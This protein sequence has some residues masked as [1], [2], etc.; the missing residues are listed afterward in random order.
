M[1]AFLSVIPHVLVG[2]VRGQINVLVTMAMLQNQTTFSIVDQFVILS[3]KTAGAIVLTNVT[4][5]KDI[6][7]MKRI[8]TFV[9]PSATHRVK[10]ETALIQMSVNVM[11]VMNTLTIQ[12]KTLVILYAIHHA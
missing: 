9:N 3:V 2:N 4:V 10:M 8:N 5:L 7:T 11:T 12:R 1:N 6:H